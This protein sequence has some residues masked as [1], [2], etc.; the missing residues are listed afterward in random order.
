MHSGLLTLAGVAAVAA[1]L[2]GSF[3]AS[4]RR[5]P[6]ELGLVPVY[7]QM[8]SGRVGFFMGANYP[9]IRFSLYDT[10]LVVGFF[11]VVVL[12]Y[13]DIV[14]AEIQQELFSRR[15]AIRS[16]SGAIFRLSVRD[17]ERVLELLGRT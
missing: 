16:K 17:P 11:S 8:C 2:I 15:L 3:F 10:F 9:A 5:A 6:V 13:K 1:L 7:E 4:R 12:P 14:R